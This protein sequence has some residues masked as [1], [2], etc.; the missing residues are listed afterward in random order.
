MVRSGDGLQVAV[1]RMPNWWILND[2]ESFRKNHSREDEQPW[3]DLAVLSALN[4]RKYSYACD[5]HGIFRDSDWTYA[6]VSLATRDLFSWVEEGPHTPG[7][8]REAEMQPLAYQLF[9]AVAWLHDLGVAHRDLSLENVVLASEE[10]RADGASSQVQ[11]KLIDFGMASLGRWQGGGGR[12]ECLN[13]A[14][15]AYKAPELHRVHSYDTFLAD[16]FALGVMLYAMAVKDFPWTCT[17][18]GQSGHF[19]LARRCG[20]SALLARRVTDS[21]KHLPEVLSSQLLNL[22]AGLLSL[23]SRDRHC[24]GEA[25]YQQ[26]GRTSATSASWFEPRSPCAELQAKP[27]ALQREESSTSAAS[28]ADTEEERCTTPTDST[29]SVRTLC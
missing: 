11:V 24:V 22:L 15:K 8:T 27:G 29:V 28:T 2:S 14:K 16:N 25:C 3:Q 13:E 10:S 12:C 7:L 5:L 6:V 9:A 26:D 21:G 18:D 20:V 4:R 19:D 1:K 23:N 17:L